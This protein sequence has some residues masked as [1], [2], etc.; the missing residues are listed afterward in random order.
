MP[1]IRTAI[2]ISGTGSN[3]EALVRAAKADDYP[4]AISLVVSN[5][6]GAIGLTTAAD[7][8]IPTLAIDHTAFGTREAFE[9]VLHAALRVHDIELVVLAGFMRVLT[10]GFVSEWQGRMI[11]IHPSLLPKHKGLHTHRRALE[12]GDTE[13]GAT[14]HWVTA[15]LDSGDMIAQDSFPIRPDDTENTLRERIRPV[16]HSL[17]PDALRI[18]AKALGRSLPTANP[19]S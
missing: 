7:L 17:Y 19:D 3:M 12:A 5:R 6:P 18:A 4:A 16:E 2:L 8:G 1:R 15:E 14:V 11:N 9:R 13:H 10:P